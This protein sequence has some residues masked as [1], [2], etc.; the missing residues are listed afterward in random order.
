MGGINNLG[1]NVGGPNNL[2]NIRNVPE[3]NNGDEAK[4]KETKEMEIKA[5]EITFLK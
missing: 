1:G 2:A 4:I 3:F 5:Y